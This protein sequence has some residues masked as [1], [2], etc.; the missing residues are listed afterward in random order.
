MKYL[1][2]LLFLAC[3]LLVFSCS[4]PCKDVDCGANGICD[5]GICNCDPGYSGTNCETNICDT[6]DCQNGDCDTVTG[7][8]TCFEG[9]EGSACD[10]EIRAKYLGTYSG[11]VAACI[12]AL[13]AGGAVPD[14]FLT[15][16]ALISVDPAN[17]NNIIMTAPNPL[18]NLGEVTVKA[19]DPFLLPTNTETIEI[20]GIPLPISITVSGSGTFINEN[21]IDITLNI[22]TILGVA[23]CTVT[24]TKQ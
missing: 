9:Y 6:T 24:M 19:G 14:E 20:P 5:E 1:S 11:S 15:L 3:T 13:G 21:T 2:Q 18:I 8:C 4:D 23:E 22:I 10:T 12:E 17:I 16:N 7:A